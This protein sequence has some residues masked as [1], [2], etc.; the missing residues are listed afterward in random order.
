MTAGINGKLFI[1][2]SIGQKKREIFS[3]W[4][5]YWSVIQWSAKLLFMRA[6]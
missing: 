6:K 3:E 2:S 5:N 1:R 4:T